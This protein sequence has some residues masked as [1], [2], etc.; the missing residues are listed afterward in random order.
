MKAQIF[1]N[2]PVQDLQKSMSQYESVGFKNEPNFTDETAACMKFSDEIYV[3]LLTHNKFKQFTSKTIANSKSNIAVINALAVE[4]REQVDEMMT[5]ALKA[6]A[7]EPTAAQDH[8]F[9]Y[10]RSFEDFDGH[11]WEVFFMDMSQIP[12][13]YAQQ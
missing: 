5:K 2:L 4:S 7:T 3:M 6:G 12:E 11:L 1:I 8:G 13:E 9:M 10:Q